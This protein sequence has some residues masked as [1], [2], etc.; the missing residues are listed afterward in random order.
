MSK[1]QRTFWT[2]IKDAKI[3]IPIIQRD[4]VYARKLSEPIR[5]KL[6]GSMVDSISDGN[7][8][9]PLF[10]DFV[11]GKT[12]GVDNFKQLERNKQSIDTLIKSIKTYANKL[13][14]GVDFETSKLHVDRAEIVTF[15]PLDGQQRITTLFLLHW[16]IAQRIENREAIEVLKRFS[17]STRSSS[18]DFLGMICSDGF[19]LVKESPMAESIENH[20]LFFV[21]WKKDPTVKAMLTVLEEFENYIDRKNIHLNNAWNKLTKG[22]QIVFNFFDLDDFELSDELYVKM[23]ARGKELTPFER[24]KA[25]LLKTCVQTNDLEK[26]RKLDINWSDLFWKFREKKDQGIDSE[27]LQYFKNLYLGDYLKSCA[28]NE[29]TNQWINLP[30]SSWIE[31]LRINTNTDPIEIFDASN[32]F[33]NNFEDYTKVLDFIEELETDY[34]I[35]SN[36][37]SDPV[38]KFLLVKNKKLSWPDQ[39]FFY[40]VTRYIIKKNNKP[41]F[42]EWLRVIS[43]LIYNTPIESPTLFVQACFSIDKLL[44]DIGDLSPY[45]AMN[46]LEVLEI[47]FF[48]QDQV[49]EEFEKVNRILS[50]PQ[51]NWLESF[52]RLEKHKLFYGQIGFLLSPKIK[53]GHVFSQFEKYAK[54]ADVLFSEPV[55]NDKTNLLFRAWLTYGPGFWKTGNDL[56]FPS[57]IRG[58]LRNRNENW[59]R[60]IDKHLDT[61]I[62]ILEDDELF[63]GDI[64]SQLENMIES[65]N[66]KDP[67]RKAIIKNPNLLLYAKQHYIRVIGEARYLLNS[68]RI[69]GYFVESL[70][71]DWFTRHKNSELEYSY[72]KGIDTID[73]TGIKLSNNLVLYLDSVSGNFVIA[74]KKIEFDNIQDALNS[75]Q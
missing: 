48:D 6:I 55:L 67:W 69:F 60:I 72:G 65:T 11:Y 29:S 70:T 23:N 35:N 27:Y 9:K 46:S 37:K 24:F 26:R 25:W 5:K 10:L 36:Y 52:N 68:S 73:S 3:E 49:I 64:I 63:E 20:E 57:N 14:V 21:Q 4:Y 74:D 61:L 51:N 66:E 32:I 62:L 38:S 44:D 12:S 7:N 43:N 22:N 13:S 56:R 30:D 1:A 45:E 40:A 34:S 2:L 28:N 15:I 71:Y 31:D 8:I 42:D 75:Y 58:T 41:H 16:L 59:R 47:S 50:N 54:R 18:K 39:C 17:Y 33:K 19:E 53:E